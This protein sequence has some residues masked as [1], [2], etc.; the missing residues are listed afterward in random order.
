[1]GCS[2]F[3]RNTPVEPY[4]GGSGIYPRLVWNDEFTGTGLPDTS[5][6]GYERGYIRNNELQYYTVGRPENARQ[7]D[8]NLII[9][10]INDSAVIDGDIRPVTSASLITRNKGDWKYGRIEVRAKLPSSLGTWPAVWMMPTKSVYGGWPKSGEID[11]M[12]HVGYDPDKIYF[13][14]H[15]EKYNHTKGTGRG[16]WIDCPS[17]DKE[18]NI[19][20]IEWFEDHIDWFFNDRKIFTIMNDEPG[21]E[22][23]PLDQPFYLILNF[24]FG[25]AWGAQRGV[26]T[27]ALPGM[28]Y[29]DY[30][31]VFQ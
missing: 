16:S 5:R 21:W 15:T 3:S 23:W 10:A 29:I 2:F 20:A 30:V 1:M 18:F 8:G 7:Q 11:I 28:Y 22:A 13:N 19:Y 4:P 27:S 25:G 31:R 9:C 17:P 12:E 24:A 26:D 14:L 6:W